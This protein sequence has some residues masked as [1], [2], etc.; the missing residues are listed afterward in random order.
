M[1]LR[2]HELLSKASSQD[3]GSG[4]CTYEAKANEVR[5]LPVREELEAQAFPSGRWRPWPSGQ[6]WQLSRR[7]ATRLGL[8]RV[9]RR[10]LGSVPA[11]PAVVRERRWGRQLA[12]AGVLAE[13][14]RGPRA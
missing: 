14:L 4:V 10:P 6:W 7:R 2:L 11:R 13:T 3:G 1:G 12:G 9:V 8:V 5:R